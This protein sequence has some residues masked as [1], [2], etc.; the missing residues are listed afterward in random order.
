MVDFAKSTNRLGVYHSFA[1][2]APATS[3]Y[4]LVA[5]LTVLQGIYITYFGF[6]LTSVALVVFLSR[7]FDAIT[8]PLIGYICDRYC[9]NG[10]TKTPFITVGC[11]L[12][13][14]SGYFLFV[15]PE[16]VSFYYFIFWFFSFYMAFTLFEIPHIT[17]GGE[18]AR[19]PEEKNIIYSWRAAAVMVGNLLFYIT[20]ML[21]FFETTSITP[22]TLKYMVVMSGCLMLPMLYMYFVTD[23]K[24][25]QKEKTFFPVGKAKNPKV[26]ILRLALIFRHRRFMLFIISFFCYGLGTGAW[27]GLI[28]IYVEHFLHLGEDFA[29]ILIVSMVSSIFMIR[30]WQSLGNYIGKQSTYAAGLFL[31]VFSI[32]LLTILRSDDGGFSPFLTL[33]TIVSIYS[34]LSVANIMAPSILSDI[35]DDTPTELGSG[36]A[37]SYFAVYSFV[38]KASSGFGAAGGLALAGY[39]GF[40]SNIV[41]SLGTENFGIQISIGYIPIIFLLLSVVSMSKTSNCMKIWNHT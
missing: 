18:L 3:V 31:A 23:F 8:D 1:Y 29:L 30:V 5:P 38:A 25:S 26:S 2:A 7:L 16:N 34:G 28:F 32:W 13:A 20:P 9:S 41:D 39:Y 6:S 15:P 22:I 14:F 19:T 24:Y 40:D 33:V 12:V 27:G 17:M 21:P 10:G 4:Y 36:F 37:A 35:I 11:I